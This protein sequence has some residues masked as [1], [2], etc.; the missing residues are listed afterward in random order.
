MDPM[1]LLGNGNAVVIDL[2]LKFSLLQS[3]KNARWIRLAT[4]FAHL[5]GWREIERGIRDTKAKARLLTGLDFCQTEPAVLKAWL[6]LTEKSS[7]EARI[8]SRRKDVFHPKVLIVHA[9]R[10]AFA[11][12]GSGNL[13]RGGL[14]NNIE[15]GL[16][17]DDEIIITQLVKWFDSKFDSEAS[18]FRSE[19]IQKYEKDYKS[20]K[21][22]LT[23]IKG[24]EKKAVERF[25]DAFDDSMV[26]WGQAVRKAQL[27]FSSS[28]FKNDDRK[29][30]LESARRVCRCL[31]YPRFNFDRQNW[32]EFYKIAELGKLDPRYKDAVFKNPT[33]LKQALR[34]LVNETIPIS[35]RI[36]ALLDVNGRHHIRGLGINTVTKILTCHR[37][38]KWPVLNSP[39]RE[40]L[41]RFG[42]REPSGEDV[43]QKYQVFQGRIMKFAQKCGAT[44]LIAV[45]S[46]FYTQSNAGS[47]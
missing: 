25:S 4:A 37:P 8:Y 34:Y 26:S 3:L 27:Y 22:W 28:G 38:E 19:E 18:T 33:R 31:D 47:K 16:Y 23:R 41:R 21:R 35:K 9:K 5:S 20:A 6:K 40:V 2:P 13:S 10:G 44:D 29:K 42:Y 17:V 45:D 7:T 30:W 14:R 15:C 11:V 1:T 39:V 24:A 36:N 32:S 46:F 43:G 12:V